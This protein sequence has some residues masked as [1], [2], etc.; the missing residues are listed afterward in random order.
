[1][2]GELLW[3]KQDGILHLT[4]S[5]ESKKNAFTERM[6]LDLTRALVH[7]RFLS[8]VKVILLS[9]AGDEFFSS[10]ND[11]TPR[12][13]DFVRLEDGSRIAS[14]WQMRNFVEAFVDNT[15]PIVAAVNGP[16][17]GV[18]CTILAFCDFVFVSQKTYFYT[19][20][21]SL[22]QGPEACSSL[23]FPE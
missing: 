4:L 3:K 2:S 12:E 13:D 19:P 23:L 1:M 15:K 18:G 6:Y 8:D 7:A 16:A 10:G 5:Y 21:M 17:I 9:G 11:I 20:F 14:Q 22:A